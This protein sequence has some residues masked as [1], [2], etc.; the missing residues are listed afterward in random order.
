MEVTTLP[1]GFRAWGQANG[2]GQRH[3]ICNLPWAALSRRRFQNRKS[4]QA[5]DPSD[6]LRNPPPRPGAREKGV[7]TRSAAAKVCD[8]RGGRA[9]KRDFGPLPI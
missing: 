7:S 4:G 2:L 1:T 9:T 5:T 6:R 8:R 3:W